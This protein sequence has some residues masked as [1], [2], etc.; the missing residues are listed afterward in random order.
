MS[1]DTGLIALRDRRE[2]V[3]A[4]LSDA[5][6][7]DLI[8]V[9][10]FE[11]RLDLA[12]RAET[13]AA[14]TTLVQ[15]LEKT[16]GGSATPT[17]ALMPAPVRAA[18]LSRVRARQLIIAVMGGAQRKGSWTPARKTRVFTLMGGA[19]LDFREA[20]FAPGLTEVHVYA[21]MGGA[22]VVVPPN[23]AVEMDGVAIMGGFDQADRAP[24]H[25]LDP[26]RP[27][28]RVTGFALMGG[29]QIET[30]LLGETAGQARRRRRRERKEQ[31]RREQRQL[32][33]QDA[34]LLSERRD[35]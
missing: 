32:E 1:D 30:R 22:H 11:R 29:V 35:E 17:H 25:N 2:Q 8:E 16:A 14:L 28:L 3:I 15:D 26:E 6:A 31:R 20:T 10:E 18:A 34:K 27:L 33:D 21:I 23:L 13:V 9:S 24:V 19:E 7:R 5:F 4:V 12:H